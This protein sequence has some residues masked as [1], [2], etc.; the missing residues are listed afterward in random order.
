MRILLIGEYSNLHHTL[1]KGLK[2]LGHQVTVASDGNVWRNY[3]RDINLKR[4]G[5]GKIDTLRYGW[6]ILK[7]LPAM[8]GYDMVQ[9]INPIFL[10]LKSDLNLKI[11]RYLKKHNG[12]VFMG[13]YGNDHY[14]VKAC[15]DRKSFRYSDFYCGERTIPNPNNPAI[16]REWMESDKKR[17]NQLIA[18]ESDGI[19]ACL[20]EY[21]VPYVKEFGEKLAYIPLPLDRSE[22]E[23][24][25]LEG[26]I[27][28]VKFF[29]GIQKKSHLSKGTDVMYE[30]L[31]EV[32]KEYPDLCEVKKTVSVPYAEYIHLMRESHVLIDQLYSYTPAMNALI[33]M[34]Q[35]LV[36]AGGAEPEMYEQL[37]ET[38]LRPIVNL[39]P[40]K[41]KVCESFR[42]IIRER[43]YLPE[44]SA[45]SIA[46][47]KKHHDHMKVAQ[48]YLAFWESR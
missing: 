20:Y 22:V 15:L 41:E 9:V 8:R 36:V 28:Q 2:A 43:E 12:K 17:V 13:A 46:F 37:N 11:F 24:R 1:S 33:G 39:Y 23:E 38:E 34:A 3:P 30:A 42:Q 7:A 14:W 45:Q 10:D 16:I 25:V 19:I 40:D 47:V 26:P 35:G 6:D 29:I 4:N 44:R 31:C 21:H 27:D 32:E 18:E 48:E 5:Y